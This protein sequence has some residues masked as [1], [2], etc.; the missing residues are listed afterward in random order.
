MW[1]AN[2]YVDR[3][4]PSNPYSVVKRKDICCVSNALESVWAS[5]NRSGAIQLVA[6]ALLT[7]GGTFLSA[8][9][10]MLQDAWKGI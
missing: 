4:L 10:N 7:Y 3:I 1:H 8:I 5:A 2:V 9:P 6:A